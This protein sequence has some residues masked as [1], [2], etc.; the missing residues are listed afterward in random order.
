[1]ILQNEILVLG[2]ELLSQFFA[3]LAS[4]NDATKAPIDTEIIVE[5]TAVLRQHLNG[6]TKA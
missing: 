2:T 5:I 3:F 1:M 6:A 4:K